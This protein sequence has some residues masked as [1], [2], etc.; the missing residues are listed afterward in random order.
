MNA[1]PTDAPIPLTQGAGY[2]GQYHRISASSSRCAASSCRPS[3]APVFSES[4][5]SCAESINGNTNSTTTCSSSSRCSTAPAVVNIYNNTTTYNSRSRFSNNTAINTA[6]KK[7]TTTTRSSSSR[8]STA[9]SPVTKKRTRMK[10]LPLGPISPNAGKGVP[11]PLDQLQQGESIA[12]VGT[13]EGRLTRSLE[14]RSKSR[15]FV[16]VPVVMARAGKGGWQ[17][18]LARVP[19]GHRKNSS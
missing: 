19:C 7:Y 9:P 11:Y 4:S 16:E 6:T 12:R 15:D 5:P 8:C 14:R 2:D 10:P 17:P 1:R 18:H 3:T 13:D